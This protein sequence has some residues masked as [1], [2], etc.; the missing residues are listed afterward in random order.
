MIGTG[1]TIGAG[2]FVIAGTVSAQH[3]GSAVLPS[4]IIATAGC[5]AAP[6][7]VGISKAE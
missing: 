2:M 7:F 5:F 6:S 4:F 1:T 3:A